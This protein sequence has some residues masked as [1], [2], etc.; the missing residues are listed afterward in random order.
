MVDA[1]AE[2]AGGRIMPSTLD[3]Q[4]ALNQRGAELVLDGKSGPATRAAI[5]AFQREA[6]LPITAI[7]GPET[8]AALGLFES[9]DPVAAASLLN[10]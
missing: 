2:Y 5:R 3:V 1:Y 10:T 4:R 9:H 8:L 7:A 6:G